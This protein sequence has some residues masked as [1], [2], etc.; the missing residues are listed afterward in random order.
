MLPESKRPSES[1][2][3]SSGRLGFG[4]FASERSNQE[5]GRVNADFAIA[6]EGTLHLLY[7]VSICLLPWHGNSFDAN[8]MRHSASNQFSLIQ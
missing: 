5:P 8:L 4:L 7:G 6:V 2:Q 1:H 3:N